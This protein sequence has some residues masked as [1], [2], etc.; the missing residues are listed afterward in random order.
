MKHFVK[1]F[2]E[3]LTQTFSARREKGRKKGAKRACGRLEAFFRSGHKIYLVG[4]RSCNALKTEPFQALLRN[5]PFC[6]LEEAGDSGAEP[7]QN[8]TA[9]AEVV[10]TVLPFVP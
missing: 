8:L 7:S 5:I 6:F 9:A 10:Q 4:F 3:L 1:C 2:F